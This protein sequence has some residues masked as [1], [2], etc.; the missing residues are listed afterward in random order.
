[1]IKLDRE[2]L[3][4]TPGLFFLYI[5]LS[6]LL[7]ILYRLIIPG[8][9][10]PL[11]YFSLGWGLVRGGINLIDL[12]PALAL[13]ALVIPFGVHQWPPEK[14]APFSPK[15]LKNLG[16]SILG[17]IVAAGVYALLF[18]LAL[19]LIRNYEADL[20]A[21]GQLWRLSAEQARSY[22][23]LGEWQE[24]DRLV[25]ICEMIWPGAPEMAGLKAETSIQL[26]GTAQRL[27]PAERNASLS[28]KDLAEF[29]PL[30]AAEAI[31]MAETALREERYYDAHWLATLG[32]DLAGP[33]SA[34]SAVAS[35]IASQAWNAVS[36]LEP[37]SRQ[38]EAYSIYHLKRD[39]YMAFISGDWVQAYYL[40]QELLSLVPGDPDG[41]HYLRLSEQGFISMAF[42]VDE[43][44]LRRNPEGAIFS[45]PKGTA[46]ERISMNQG[47]G[48]MVMRFSS[49]SIFPD[50]AYGYGLEILDFDQAGRLLWRLETPYVK[51]LPLSQETGSHVLML[52]RAFDRVDGQR[53]WE[54]EIR[55]YGDAAPRNAQLTLDLTWDEFRLLAQMRRGQ[56]ILNLGELIAATAIGPDYGY[57]PEVFEAELISRF[58]EPVLFLPILIFI[59]TVAWRYRAVK[60]P[61]FIWLP[62]LGI[63]PLVFNGAVYFCRNSLYN[64]SIWAVIYLGFSLAV[65]V[66]TAGA[67]FLFILSLIILSSQHG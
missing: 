54:P 65:T 12:F 15:F 64:V 57:L 46:E 66:L 26:E 6:S 18:L 13:S 20:R 48:R 16:P 5:V 8:E 42:F 39:A 44:E 23:A 45:L 10:P 35:R 53:R 27:E 43:M 29:R 34:D 33:G 55:N 36:S 11:A 17:A 1:M 52:L 25:N 59:L 22:A 58:A 38:T 24:V 9:V 62:M 60:K 30:T 3:F 31:Q 14:F 51:M 4:S 2:K 21:R 19:P 41:L 40:F 63:L 56:D 7:V 67:V 37:N 32:V 61:R 47:M 49:L 50:S 28:L